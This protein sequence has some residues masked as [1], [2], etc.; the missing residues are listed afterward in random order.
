MVDGFNVD[1]FLVT[2]IR[3]SPPQVHRCTATLPRAH[4][5]SPAVAVPTVV[6]GVVGVWPGV[7]ISGSR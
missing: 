5:G 1:H 2:T 7:V 3:L 4:G 6:T